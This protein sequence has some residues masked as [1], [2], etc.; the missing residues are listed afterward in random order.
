MFGGFPPE[1]WMLISSLPLL[2]GGIVFQ[3]TTINLLLSLVLGPP[4]L[5]RST[6]IRSSSSPGS[7]TGGFFSCLKMLWTMKQVVYHSPHLCKRSLSTFVHESIFS[8]FVG[9]AA[10]A[11]FVRG[12]GFILVPVSVTV[13]AHTVSLV[14]IT[15]YHIELPQWWLS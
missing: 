10:C 7:D 6:L 13:S 2:E 4:S 3:W 8:P 11:Y 12:I 5:T 15:I 9:Q 14:Q 1:F